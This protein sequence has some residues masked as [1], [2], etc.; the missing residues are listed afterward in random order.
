MFQFLKR[1]WPF[2][3]ASRLEESDYALSQCCKTLA[4]CQ[5]RLREA[6]FQLG[7]AREQL[8]LAQA[9]ALEFQK[10]IEP[11]LS[12]MF[13]LRKWC[14]TAIREIQAGQREQVFFAKPQI[15]RLD[16]SAIPVG[17]TEK[18]VVPM[19]ELK[20]TVGLAP[21]AAPEAIARHLA[22]VIVD[23]VMVRWQD[24]SILSRK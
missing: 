22:E 9:R 12:D 3:R 20:M 13:D 6:V 2:V 15:A 14:R 19:H 24:Q 4:D 5:G 7:L 21:G 17:P 23:A 1:L 11:L 18:I 16:D 8:G 10:T